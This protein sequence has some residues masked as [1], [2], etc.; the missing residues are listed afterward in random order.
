M[1]YIPATDKETAGSLVS[2]RFAVEFLKS[3][4][5]KASD[6]AGKK[7]RAFAASAKN[8]PIWAGWTEKCF[9]IF[10]IYVSE[11]AFGM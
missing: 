8:D 11:E 6:Q 5:K 1:F 2:L 9:K 3:V 4:A 10:K 7:L